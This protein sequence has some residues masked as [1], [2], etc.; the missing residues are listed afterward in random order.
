MK[1][2]WKIIIAVTVIVAGII[3]LLPVITGNG[4][5]IISFRTEKAG[6]ASLNLRSQQ[7]V[8]LNL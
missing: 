6:A 5:E 3:A 1:K 4:K 2:K 7:A 8:I